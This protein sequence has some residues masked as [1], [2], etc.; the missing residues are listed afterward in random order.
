MPAPGTAGGVESAEIEVLTAGHD[1]SI[2][3][4][5]DYSPEQVDI[6]AI[7]DIDRFLAEHRPPWAAVRWINVD[8][9]GDADV[10]RALAAKYGLHPLAMEDVL[11]TIERPKAEDFPGTEEQPGRLF[12]VAR[13]IHER[14]G[15]LDSD[16]VS[17][18]LGRTTLLSF[19]DAHRGDMESVRQRIRMDGSRLRQNDA[20]FLLYAILDAMVDH[21]FPVLEHAS[22]RLE[23]LEAEVLERPTHDAL[24]RI[25]LLKRELL[26]I[27]RSAWPMRDLMVDLQREQ[28]ECLSDAAQVYLRDVHDH[29]V[30]IIDL[31][32]IYREIASGVAETYVSVLSNRTSDTVKVLTIIGTI[33]IPLTFLAGVYGMNMPIPENESALAY[34]LFWVACIMVAGGM[35]LWFRRRGFL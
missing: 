4:C 23:G 24:T 9:L 31:V 35:L 28:H 14:D 7:H 22:E 19:Q 21:Y 32:E 33:F 30:Q 26:T 6:R 11:R 25:H 34:P 29:C 27:R 18:F 10:I 16:Q 20:S 1:P 3:T 13:T 15:R 8:G 5:V 12:V 2:V 17:L